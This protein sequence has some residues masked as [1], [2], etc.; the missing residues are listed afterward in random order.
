MPNKESLSSVLDRTCAHLEN[1]ESLGISQLPMDN[2]KKIRNELGDCTR[3]KLHKL[4]RKQIVFGVGNP[5]AELMF[6]GEAPGR[7]EDA[8]GEPFVGLAG[9]LLNKIIQAIGME[10]EQVYIANVIK[11]RPPQN[12]NPEPDELESCEPFWQKQIR[13]IKPRILVPLGSVAA[14]T[15]LATDLGISK[16]RGR[17][18]DFEGIP[19]IPTYHPAYLLRS[20]NKKR[21]TWED[22]KKVRDFLK[23]NTN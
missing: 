6:I 21:D 2:L 13:A 20:P 9:K 16:L 23:G 12:R 18:H 22:M 4:G 19:V 7:D 14:K 8:K 5:V 3:C 1:L 11:C 10:R 17:L 15:V